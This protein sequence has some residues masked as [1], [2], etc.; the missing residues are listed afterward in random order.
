MA[1]K[2]KPPLPTDWS[3]LDG[4]N[5]VLVCVPKGREYQAI[6]EGA[7]QRALN[8]WKYDISIGNIDEFKLEWNKVLLSIMTCDL[9]LLTTQVTR[10]A[11]SLES[12]DAKL[13][14]I[15]TWDEMV[16]DLEAAL[17]AGHFAV[18][19]LKGLFDL[20]PSFK[21]KVDATRLVMSFWEYYSWK[22]PILAALVGFQT[23]LAAMAAALATSAGLAATHTTLLGITSIA[24]AGQFLKD[25]AFGDKN[26]MDDLIKPLWD[27]WI[28]DGDG[29]LGGEDPDSDPA[30]NN[31]VNVLIRQEAMTQSVT[32]MCG[33]GGGGCNG[34]GGS[35]PEDGS[36]G[37]GGLSDG[38]NY[39]Q[40]SPGGNPPGDWTNWTGYDGFEPYKCKA[41]NALVLGFAESLAVLG[42]FRESNITGATHQLIVAR[43]E[44]S[45]KNLTAGI[46]SLPFIGDS[47]SGVGLSIRSWTAAQI[48]IAVD[49]AM[50]LIGLADL[51]VFNDI[52]LDVLNNRA[53]L[54]C[55]LY[56]AKDSAAARLVFTDHVSAYLDSTSWSSNVQDYADLIIDNV[57]S[58]N[59]VNTLWVKDALINRY[60]DSTSTDCASC[61][62]YTITYGSLVS[63]DGTT[64]SAS[65]GV[66]PFNF[67][68]SGYGILIVFDNA[69]DFDT[70][71]VIGLTH[72]IT[73]A[74]S[75]AGDYPW[76]FAW[77]DADLAQNLETDKTLVQSPAVF[78]VLNGRGIHLISDTPFTVD[79]VRV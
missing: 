56:C 36:S 66:W 13:Q 46:A 74:P 33:C 12:A 21:L 65:S 38:Q 52:R 73:G 40:P 62:G 17:G 67:G 30:L 76:P 69:L 51:Q 22:A 53:S 57:V 63:D 79:F 47:L 48:A 42:E 9:E 25:V 34:C 78:S 49:S 32:V 15:Y 5:L 77:Y 23:T 41:S 35:L 43:V 55:G 61:S 31:L 68:C 75:C 3:S 10:I 29:G 60:V 26:L 7:L 19:L 11:D 50:P 4:Y 24:N 44:N 39:N 8:L 71:N 72:P 28:S 16:A 70:Q 45:L 18:V 27:N 64:I 54:V 2:S 6:F 1:D 58:N 37:V 20:M 59:Y 14:E